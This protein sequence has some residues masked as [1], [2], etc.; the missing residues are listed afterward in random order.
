MAAG[1]GNARPALPLDLS[2]WAAPLPTAALPSLC[3]RVPFQCQLLETVATESLPFSSSRSLLN[4]CKHGHP[5][6]L[7]P[8]SRGVTNG[9]LV[10]APVRSFQC[11]SILT[12]LRRSHCWPRLLGSLVFSSAWRYHPFRWVSWV[13]P[14][15]S[16]RWP[17]SFCGALEILLFSKFPVVVPFYL[18]TLT[19]PCGLSFLNS[20]T[21][22]S[23]SL[24]TMSTW[25]AGSI[26][27]QTCPELNIFV[28]WIV[29][30]DPVP[31]VRDI[32]LPSW[33]TGS[34]SSFLITQGNCLL[35]LHF[36]CQRDGLLLPM[37]ATKPSA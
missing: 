31:T 8:P 7:R 1:D 6:T 12:S 33:S 15:S 5:A 29:S 18:V 4:S 34:S 3:L 21:S 11:L 2:L 30:L 37:H 16:I 36:S 9:F 26:S 25:L 35:V 20:T 17:L 27:I 19:F 23:N 28:Q 22:M 24:P 13:P 32:T 10:S 14:T